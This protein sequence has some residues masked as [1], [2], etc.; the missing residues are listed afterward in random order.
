MQGRTRRGGGPKLTTTQKK[1]I[2]SK[3]KKLHL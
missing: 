1:N 3:S 2:L